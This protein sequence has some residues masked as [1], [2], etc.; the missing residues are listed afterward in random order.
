MRLPQNAIGY[1][2]LPYQWGYVAGAISGDGC[3]YY[4]WG[5][6]NVHG[7]KYRYPIAEL[8]VRDYDFANNLAECVGDITKRPTVE[9]LTSKRDGHWYIVRIYCRELVNQLTGWNTGT[10]CHIWSVPDVI[11]NNKELSRGF[12]NGYFDAEGSVSF[13]KGKY[14]YL[15]LSSVNGE[16]LDSVCDLIKSFGIICRTYFDEKWHSYHLSVYG[17]EAIKYWDKIGIAPGI[18]QSKLAQFING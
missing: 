11:F 4:Y 2:H 7:E 13:D 5:G 12:I 9:S 6:K 18:K 10:G 17:N 15:R 8:K 16:G 14:P 3:I 1:E